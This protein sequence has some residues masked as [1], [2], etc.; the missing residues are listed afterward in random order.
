MILWCR[1]TYY[2]KG[3]FTSYNNRIYNFSGAGDMDPSLENIYIENLKTH[4]ISVFDSTTTTEMD[5]IN[6]L[7]FDSHY[8]GNLELNR[9][10]FQLDAALLTYSNALQ[11]HT[12]LTSRIKPNF[13]KTSK[14]QCKGGEK[15]NCP[16]G[17]K[18]RLG[19]NVVLLTDL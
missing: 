16:L 3:H 8:F 19:N 15:L 17:V 14:P 10:L 12:C 11:A 7:T 18:G 6:A 4:C 9:G 13:L 2:W 5:I 1:C